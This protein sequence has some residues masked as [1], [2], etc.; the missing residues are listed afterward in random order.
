M[1][2]CGF[3]KTQLLGIAFQA[4]GKDAKRNVTDVFI[5]SVTALG[6]AGEYCSR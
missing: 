3:K 6:I 2:L 1:S 4:I 5:S